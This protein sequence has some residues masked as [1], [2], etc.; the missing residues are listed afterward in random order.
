MGK[1]Q[2]VSSVSPSSQTLSFSAQPL[3]MKGL[4]SFLCLPPTDDTTLMVEHEE[5]LK[6]LLMKVK[7]ESDK[8]GLKLTIQKTKEY[9]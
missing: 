5:K 7:E 2:S 4:C 9:L 6:S 8:V 3:L 1:L